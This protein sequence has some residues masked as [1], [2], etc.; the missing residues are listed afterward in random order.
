[1][2]IGIS[3][4]LLD[5]GYDSFQCNN[6]LKEKRCQKPLDLL[7]VSISGGG[8]LS[9][10]RPYSLE[11]FNKAGDQMPADKIKYKISN[12]YTS[13]LDLIYPVGALYISSVNTSPASLFGG[14]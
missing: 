3:P 9:N 10:F 14:T 1:M 2:I 11:M 5:E 8:A 12:T 7:S 4:P 6:H 13:L